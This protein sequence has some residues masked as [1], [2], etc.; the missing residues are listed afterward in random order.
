MFL[1]ASWQ[2]LGTGKV[3]SIFALL[4]FLCDFVAMR[5]GSVATHHI[6]VLSV[7]YVHEGLFNGECGN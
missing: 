5:L 6:S 3:L 2:V 1:P 7:I 4:N